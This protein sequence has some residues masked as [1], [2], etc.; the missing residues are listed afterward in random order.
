MGDRVSIQFVNRQ[1]SNEDDG[2]V[3]F[4]HWGG[5]D[6]PREA[7][8]YAIKLKQWA[9]AEH[10][11]HPNGSAPLDRLEVRVVMTDFM[12]HLATNTEW[13][14]HTD[15]KTG[16]P[17]GRCNDSIY[18]GRTENDGDNSD[19]GHFKIDVNNPEASLE[20]ERFHENDDED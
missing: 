12:L 11:R 3:L 2:V 7:I 8:D 6:F 5:L 16:K 20:D 17:T 19:N 18:F 10:T 4:N 13:L 1:E 15:Y 9:D 14:I